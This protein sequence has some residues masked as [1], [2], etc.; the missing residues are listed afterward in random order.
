LQTVPDPETWSTAP[1]RWQK[2]VEVMGRRVYEAKPV[3]PIDYKNPLPPRAVWRDRAA[4]PL[5]EKYWN[6]GD[7]QTSLDDPA[8]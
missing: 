5:V 7:Y 2:R 4:G 3:E 1:S 6:C 8:P